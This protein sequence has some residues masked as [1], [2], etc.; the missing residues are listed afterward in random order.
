M[1]FTASRSGD[2]ETIVTRQSPG[3]SSRDFARG[4]RRVLVIK[5][6]GVEIPCTRWCPGGRSGSEGWRSG[7]VVLGHLVRGGHPSFLDRH[8][9]ARLRLRGAVVALL[10]GAT[11]EMGG[12]ELAAAGGIA[13][14]RRAR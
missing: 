10:E 14:S 3:S 8:L 2:E 13:T 4:K 7:Q 1:L 11:D 12:L 5:A 9:S 6:E